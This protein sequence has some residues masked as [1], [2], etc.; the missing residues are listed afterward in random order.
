LLDVPTCKFG[1]KLDRHWT[2][3]AHTFAAG[4]NDE[5][6][7]LQGLSLV[8]GAR[9]VPPSDARIVQHYRLAR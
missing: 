5:R 8:A 2:V 9:F 1:E 7:C 6:P 4:F 3:G